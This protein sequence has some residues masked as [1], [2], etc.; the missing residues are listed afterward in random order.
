MRRGQFVQSLL[1]SPHYDMNHTRYFFFV[2]LFFLN[3]ALQVRESVDR[4]LKISRELV[5]GR[6][7][8]LLV[9]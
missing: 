7:V 9:G 3:E 2:F 6:L 4:L 5:I 8:C 1:P